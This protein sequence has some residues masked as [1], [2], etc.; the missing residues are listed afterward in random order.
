[1]DQKILFDTISNA[2]KCRPGDLVY[3]LDRQHKTINPRK[4][5]EIEISITEKNPKIRLILTPAGYHAPEH[6]GFTLFFTKEA[7]E[8]ALEKLIN[9]GR[10]K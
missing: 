6:F 7:A 4:I 8:Q 1:M 10:K 9:E 5:F 3:W 2:L